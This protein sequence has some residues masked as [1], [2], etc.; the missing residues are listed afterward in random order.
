M[1]KSLLAVAI[2][3]ICLF[4]S[5][6]AGCVSIE[7][8]TKKANRSDNLVKICERRTGQPECYYIDRYE[9]EQQLRN[10]MIY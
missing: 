2:I 1:K 10:M 7:S 9:L 6:M 8:G 5:V 3:L 4:I